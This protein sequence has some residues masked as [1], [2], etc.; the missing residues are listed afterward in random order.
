MAKAKAQPKA[1]A[2]AKPPTAKASGGEES[3]RSLIWLQGLICGGVVTLA[4]ASALL[5]GALLAPALLA[6]RLDRQPGRPVAR[7]VLV[8]ALAGAIQPLYALWQGGHSLA[9]AGLLLSDPANLLP[10]WSAAAGGWL[11]A[12]LAPLGVRMVLELG[13][14]T[15][16]ARLRAERARLESE[17]GIAP[18]KAEADDAQAEA[19]ASASP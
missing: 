15:R 12:E 14:H 16:A 1:K 2:K 4:P 19:P 9:L 8:C 3:P 18:A 11:L 6:H 17:W 5:G 13:V 7:A 10:S